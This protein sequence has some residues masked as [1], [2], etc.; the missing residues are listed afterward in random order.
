MRG[1]RAMSH[2]RAMLLRLGRGFRATAAQ[3]RQHIALAQFDVFLSEQS[4]DHHSLAIPISDEGGGIEALV[5]AFAKQGR[6]ARVEYFHDLYPG[7]AAALEGKGFELE[8]DAPLMTLEAAGLAPGGRAEGYKRLGPS[9]GGL[10]EDFFRR[11]SIAFG[12]DGGDGSLSWLPQ[13]GSG[14]ERGTVMAACI[15]CDGQPVTGAVIQGAD[16]AELAGV[17]TFPDMRMQGLA[18][19]VCQNLLTDYYLSRG[20]CWLSSAEDALK[21][22]EK[23]GFKRVGSQRNYRRAGREAQAVG[24]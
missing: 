10:M 21:L 16:D 14:L 9:D 7:L 3:D 5:E 1:V 11:Q 4:G 22:Y 17:W 24:A 19:A 12:G 15:L 20:L 18:F 2:D 13:V 8:M 6:P 23:L